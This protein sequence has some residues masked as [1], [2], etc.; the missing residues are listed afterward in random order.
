MTLKT[1]YVSPKSVIKRTG[2]LKFGNNLYID[3]N[4]YIDAFSEGGLILGDN[5]IIGKNTTIE[6]SGNRDYPGRGIKVGNNTSL[7]TNG[8]YGG[9]GGVIIGDDVL[10]GNYVSFHPENHIFDDFNQL[11]SKQ[12]VSHKGIKIGSNVW[13]GTKATI[14]DGAEIGDGCIV[15]ACACVTGKFP[16]NCVIGGVPAKILKYRNQSVS[17]H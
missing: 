1:V 6:V 5:V 8:F 2:K 10:I 15:A 14:L 4:C 12:G 9:A 16:S 7:G 3:Y 17:H 11:I 13:I